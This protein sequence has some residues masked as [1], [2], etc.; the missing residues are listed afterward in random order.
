GKS[1]NP[2][3]MVTELLS[4]ERENEVAMKSIVVENGFP[5]HFSKEALRQAAS[6]PAQLDGA[7]IAKRKDCREFPTLTIDPA[8][9]KDFDDAL[10]VRTLK[11]GL[12]EVGVHIADVSHY[13][14][15]NS[16]LD[17]EAYE[18]ATSVYFPDRVSPMLPERIS[19]EL[20]SLRPNEDKFTFSVMFQLTRQGEVKQYW[21][22][23][24]VIHSDK[25]LAYEEA[26]QVIETGQGSWKESILLL[27]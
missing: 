16:I 14:P 23:R 24:T 9:A 17:S 10:S 6:L 11:N 4:G 3:G 13:L 5:L 20:C 1:K 2:V 22:G 26:Q 19:N 7:E 12:I 18:R 8:D 15:E 27:H 25:R 21:I